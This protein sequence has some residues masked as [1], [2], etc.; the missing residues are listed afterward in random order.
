MIAICV[1]GA[2]MITEKIKKFLASPLGA[3][4]YA[5]VTGMVGIF[6][7][8]AFFTMILTPSAIVLALP[9]MVAFNSAA[10]GYSIAEKQRG[11]F[12][13]PWPALI[14]LSLVLSAV[15]GVAIVMFYP[16]ESLWEGTRYLITGLFAM[17][18][19]YIGAWIGG[20]SKNLNRSSRS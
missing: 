12:R 10:G 20:K 11:E 15:S 4:I 14:V 6:I 2:E 5:L 16:W 19:S 1:H 3:F 13:Y 17:V 18:F 9:A 8:V 7:L